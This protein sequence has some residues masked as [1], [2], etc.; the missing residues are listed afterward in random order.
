MLYFFLIIQIS[1]ATS[2]FPFSKSAGNIQCIS[3]HPSRPF[4]FVATQQHVK[5]YH[6]IEQKMIKRL[7]SGVKWISAMD[8]HPSGDHIIVSSYDK[9]IIWFDLDLSSSPYK[10]LKYHEK[11]VRHVQY[12]K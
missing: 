12:H 9:R 6:L 1:K 5:I 7:I 11:A 2:Q 3:F 4:L 10:T 8:V